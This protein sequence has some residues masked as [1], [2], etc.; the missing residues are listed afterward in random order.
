MSWTVSHNFRKNGSKIIGTN[1]GQYL[2]DMLNEVKRVATDGDFGKDSE[3]CIIIRRE[4]ETDQETK[5]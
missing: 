3:D 4:D 2:N 1:P 5:G